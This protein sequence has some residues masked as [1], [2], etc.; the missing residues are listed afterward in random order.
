MFS[1]QVPVGKGGLPLVPTAAQMRSLKKGSSEQLAIT[2]DSESERLLDKAESV[3]DKGLVLK[4][5]SIVYS[6]LGCIIW[7][8]FY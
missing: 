7:E 4:R 5:I 2:I 1:L 6:I 8:A 3:E